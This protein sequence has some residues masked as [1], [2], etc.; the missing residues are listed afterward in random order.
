[1]M[2]ALCIAIAPSCTRNACHACR[3]CG[4][5]A[6]KL[7]TSSFI[8]AAKTKCTCGREALTISPSSLLY[9]ISSF[10]SRLNLDITQLTRLVQMLGLLVPNKCTHINLIIVNGIYEVKTRGV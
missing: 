1:M 8:S 2:P 6:G 7:A 9:L 10:V 3:W 4:R 5:S